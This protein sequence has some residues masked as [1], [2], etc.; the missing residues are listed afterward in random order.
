MYVDV[1]LNMQQ[2][3]IIKPTDVLIGSSGD[4]HSI[5]MLSLCD[6]E[7]FIFLLSVF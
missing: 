2:Y 1:I 3:I 6:L 5:N 7:K 4:N